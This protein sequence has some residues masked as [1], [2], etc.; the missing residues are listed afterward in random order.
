MRKHRRLQDVQAKVAR[1]LQDVEPVNGIGI[2]RTPKGHFCIKVNLT[3]ED[4]AVRKKVR[5]LS[6]V[7]SFPICVEIVGLVEALRSRQFASHR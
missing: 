7:L 4:R 3:R 5:K 1:E 2:G 6:R